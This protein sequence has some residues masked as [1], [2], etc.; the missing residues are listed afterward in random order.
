[1]MGNFFIAEH[2][3]SAREN[4]INLLGELSDLCGES[5]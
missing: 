1:M 2:A 3:E 5:S 4:K